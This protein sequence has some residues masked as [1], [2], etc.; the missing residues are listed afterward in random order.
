MSPLVTST[1]RV[2]IQFNPEFRL[3]VFC[4]HSFVV[5]NTFISLAP[6]CWWKL[7]NFSE[8]RVGLGGRGRDSYGDHPKKRGP[9]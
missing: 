4:F 1:R 6:A 5:K 8:K 3:I 2:L 7:S 9:W